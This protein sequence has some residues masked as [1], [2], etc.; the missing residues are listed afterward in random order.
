MIRTDERARRRRTLGAA[1]PVRRREPTGRYHAGPA[2]LPVP[3]ALDPRTAEA[4]YELCPP[5]YRDHEVLR[6]HPRLLPRL[7]RHH[8]LADLAELRQ[9]YSDLRRDL[10]D[11]VPVH[12]IPQ[13]LATYKAEAAEL[14]RALERL[15]AIE[16]TLPP[17]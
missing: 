3:A 1:Q 12:V 17:R 14:H 7:A 2:T 6:R 5:G 9:G 13:A 10:R 16:W 8:L 4:L 15:N 11:Q